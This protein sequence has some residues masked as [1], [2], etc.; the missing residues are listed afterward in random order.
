MLPSTSNGKPDR[1]R[2]SSEKRESHPTPLIS[3]QENE[4]N[5]DGDSQPPLKL[6]VTET[7]RCRTRRSGST[8]A[9]P[10]NGTNMSREIKRELEEEYD[11]LDGKIDKGDTKEGLPSFRSRNL[12]SQGSSDKIPVSLNFVTL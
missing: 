4:T 9:K 8:G 6:D 12:L 2:R 10:E 1:R 11:A 3:D 7:P 5:T